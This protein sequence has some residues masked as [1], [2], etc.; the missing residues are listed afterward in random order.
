[1]SITLPDEARRQA[2]ASISRYF[3][4]KLEMDCGELQSRLLLDFFLEELAPSVYNEAIKDAQKY[5]QDHVAD[6]EAACYEME[7]AYWQK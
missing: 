5:F 4:E 6:L 7:F 2:L 3:E 1:M